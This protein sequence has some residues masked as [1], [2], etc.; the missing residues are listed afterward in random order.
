MSR[1]TIN[2]SLLIATRETCLV[3]HSRYRPRMEKSHSCWPRTVWRVVNMFHKNGMRPL[4]IANGIKCYSILYCNS[5]SLN[6]RLKYTYS[7]IS[8]I[9]DSL[10]GNTKKQGIDKFVAFGVRLVHSWA[11]SLVTIVMSLFWRLIFFVGQFICLVWQLIGLFWKQHTRHVS[12]DTHDMSLLRIVMGFIWQQS[13]F[14]FDTRNP[15]LVENYRVAKTHRIPHL[16]RL[17]SVKV[18]YI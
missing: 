16:Y 9:V 15:S 14:S 7:V 13:F 1:L 10:P 12:F 11:V 2:R 4:I 3:W 17:F 6:I 8:V 18:T 5:K